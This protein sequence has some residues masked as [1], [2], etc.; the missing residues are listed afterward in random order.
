MAEHAAVITKPWWHR[1]LTLEPAIVRGVIGSLVALALVW[2]LDF[3]DLGEQLKESADIIGSL[4]ALVTAW[5]TRSV[6]T[7]AGQVEARVDP[8]TGVTVA[9][10]A[11]EL[12]TGTE[13]G[14][15]PITRGV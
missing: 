2:G 9:G 8:D 7:P 1:L 6:V 3:T 10:P 5:W 14:V 12:A 15:F 13:V 4:V 11:H